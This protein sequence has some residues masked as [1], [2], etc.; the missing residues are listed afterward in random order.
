MTKP[1]VKMLRTQ[2]MTKPH[3]KMLRT[4]GEGEGR[5]KDQKRG[6]QAGRGGWGGRP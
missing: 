1:H 2:G 3:V 4:Q 5:K 6:T